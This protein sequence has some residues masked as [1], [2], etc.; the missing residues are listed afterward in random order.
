MS[1][2]RTSHGGGPSGYRTYGQWISF[3]QMCRWA[4]SSREARAVETLE[5]KKGQRFRASPGGRERRAVGATNIQH[6]Y[7]LDKVDFY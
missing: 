6:I 2:R 3:P 4:S 1:C 5:S 7:N